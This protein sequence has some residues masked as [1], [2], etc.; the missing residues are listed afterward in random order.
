MTF[1]IKEEDIDNETNRAI[2]YFRSI[3]PGSILTWNANFKLDFWTHKDDE[4]LELVFEDNSVSKQLL[5]NYF[6]HKSVGYFGTVEQIEKNDKLLF[7]KIE[8]TH[9]DLIAKVH[10]LKGKTVG[11]CEVSFANPFD[12]ENQLG[13]KPRTK[14][15]V[16]VNNWIIFFKFME[17]TI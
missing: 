2:H 1:L 17:V 4:E 15:L 10:L 6:F 16:P 11:F 13:Y 3:K 5:L 9:D 14:E 12:T 7:L 8:W